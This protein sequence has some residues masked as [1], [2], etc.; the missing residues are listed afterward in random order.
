RRQES[1]TRLCG[2]AQSYRLPDC[3]QPPERSPH[4]L[5]QDR[6]RLTRLQFHW[7]A[8][9]SGTI[10]GF[11]ARPVTEALHSPRAARLGQICPEFHIPFPSHPTFCATNG[12]SSPRTLWSKRLSEKYSRCIRS[13]FPAR[14]FNAGVACAFFTI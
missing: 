14:T 5:H 4:S 12:A 7:A 1:A 3:A 11:P 9:S 8:H 10:G 13:R 6:P 2:A